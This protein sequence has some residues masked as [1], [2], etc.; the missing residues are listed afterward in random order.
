MEQTK[1]IEAPI[2]ENSRNKAEGFEYPE[3]EELREPIQEIIKQL[4]SKIEK[5]EYGYVV[6]DDASGR[7]PALI[8][9]SFLKK[10][11]EEK[12][13]GSPKT[14][15]FATGRSNTTDVN[16]W[17]LAEIAKSVEDFF[18]TN[19]DNNRNNKVLLVSEY[20]A[21]GQSLGIICDALKKE[22]I[23]YDIATVSSAFPDDVEDTQDRLGAT[24]YDGVYSS[25]PSVY[26]NLPSVYSK[27]YI[28]G[29]QKDKNEKRIF[30]HRAA[31]IV[32]QQQEKIN[33]AR[34]DVA[35][36]SEQIFK[37]YKNLP[38]AESST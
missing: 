33:L 25:L 14:F 30:S 32:S 8:V 34:K 13:L 21:T 3:I 2:G 9:S 29:V 24:I 35:L 10:V 23:A 26:S 19:P 1:S 18:E 7:I 38:P 36:L 17:K 11:Y 27:K 5:G 4:R 15:F 12:G 28:S 22:K 16:D 6:G 37:W 31:I 20:I